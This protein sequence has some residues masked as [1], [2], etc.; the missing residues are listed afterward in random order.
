M[1]L[2]LKNKSYKVSD[3]TKV[4]LHNHSL[5][6]R[7]S[8][9]NPESYIKEAIK[10]DLEI[11][12]LSEHCPLP[13][14]FPH[15]GIEKEKIPDFFREMN[16]LKKKYQRQIKV[17]TGMEIDYLHFNLPF[18]LSILNLPLDYMIG[19]VHFLKVKGQRITVD[20]NKE[21]FERILKTIFDNKISA[22]CQSYYQTI[23]ALVKL[24]KF[25]IIGH[26][27]LIKKFNKDDK[28]FSEKENWYQKIIDKIIKEIKENQIIVEVSTAGLRKLVGKIYPSPWI[29]EKL[30]S[31]KIPLIFSADAH[32]ASLITDHFPDLNKKFINL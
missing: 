22:F 27:D 25:D 13:F 17:L 30:I 21:E 12:G 1:L 32:K 23:T 6:S 2:K 29:V 4:S 16:L 3:L 14:F 7:D 9:D 26:L 31:N 10:Q 19:S 8:T 24:R 11:I 18:S 5:Y 15:C 20:L 28:Y